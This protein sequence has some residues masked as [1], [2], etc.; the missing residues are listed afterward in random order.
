MK[1]A[2]PQILQPAHWPR[3]KGFSHGMAARGRLLFVAGQVGWDSTGRFAS[4]RL[5]DGSVWCERRSSSP[6]GGRKTGPGVMITARS[7]KFCS[8]RTLPGQL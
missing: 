3:P 2:A 1:S 4:V 8:S 5:A 7:T 6:I